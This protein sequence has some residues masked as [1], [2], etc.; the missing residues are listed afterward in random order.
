MHVVPFA[1]LGCAVD[2]VI[3]HV[4]ATGIGYQTIDHH[5]LAV[6]AAPNVVDERKAN[7]VELINLDA[8]GPYGVEIGTAH[9]LIVA[10]VAKAVEEQSHFYA[11]FH[12]GSQMA[13]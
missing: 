13:D 4:H 2:V 5:N 8:F 11:L 7:G 12:L 6:V 3:G 1:H 9:G 10:D